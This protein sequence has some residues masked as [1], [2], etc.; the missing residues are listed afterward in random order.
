MPRN[1]QLKEPQQSSKVASAFIEKKRREKGLS[2][3]QIAQAIGGKT[4]QSYVSNRLNCLTSWSM[5]DLDKIA[6]LFGY[7]DA[8]DMMVAARTEGE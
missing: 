7:K 6:E 2:Q 4:T 1:D 3:K 8:I 5:D